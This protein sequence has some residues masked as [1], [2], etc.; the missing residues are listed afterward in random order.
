M[1]KLG[2]LFSQKSVNKSA[3]SR[4]TGISS[5]RLSELSRNNN[6]KIRA[7]ELYLISLALEIPIDE[8]NEK[9]YKHLQLK[10]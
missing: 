9:L 3:I 10:N 5:A 2:D 8:I 4:K 6:T 7:E 1:T